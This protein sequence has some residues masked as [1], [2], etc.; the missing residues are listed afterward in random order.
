[1]IGRE[2]RR[3][4]PGEQEESCLMKNYAGRIDAD[5]GLAPRHVSIATMK[6]YIQKPVRI[7]AVDRCSCASKAS[8]FCRR[9]STPPIRA[10]TRDR[11]YRAQAFSDV[12]VL[13]GPVKYSVGMVGSHHDDS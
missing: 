11:A 6:I 3:T 1:M 7:F 2:P 13:P 4:A 12:G 5:I 8:L 9:T 10:M